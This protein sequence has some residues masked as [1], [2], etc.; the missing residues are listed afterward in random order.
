MPLDYKLTIGAR[1]ISRG[2]FM[3]AFFAGFQKSAS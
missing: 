3:R 2:D 1:E